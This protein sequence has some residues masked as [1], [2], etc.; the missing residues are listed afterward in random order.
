MYGAATVY[1][2]RIIPNVRPIICGA[3]ILLSSSKNALR[4]QLL[5]CRRRGFSGSSSELC[6][7]SPAKKAKTFI[8][9]LGHEPRIAT[10]VVDVLS[11]TG[12]SGGALLSTVRS[13]AGRWE[14]GEDAGLEELIESV[15]QE[16]ARTE[17]KKMIKFWCI[18][19]NAWSSDINDDDDDN[20]NIKSNNKDEMLK[21]AF[22]VEGFE[23]MTITDVAK[24]GDGK[25]ASVLGE[26]IEC[27]CSGIMA[28]STCH[29]VIHPD[30]F[31][32]DGSKVSKPQ[33]AEQDM[34]DLAYNPKETSRLG[35]QVVLTPEL[36][37]MI[38]MLPKGAN[39]MMDFIPFEDN[40]SKY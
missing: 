20:C 6:D 11:K 21:A 15:K 2:R 1:I 18:P 19:P 3:D 39:N 22:A 36:D 35:C 33:E 38:I 17:G 40:E 30:W 8:I 25:G 31:N 26:H 9:S 14:I 23:G 34:I 7:E 28:C 5:F 24:F 13:M 12:L 37:G 32:D 16:I 10:G 27:A 29:V 4:S